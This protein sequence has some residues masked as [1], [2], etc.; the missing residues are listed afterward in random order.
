MCCTFFCYLDNAGH[1]FHGGGGVFPCATQSN[2][3]WQCSQLPWLSFVTTRL[4]FKV[5]NT[6]FCV[7]L[8]LHCAKSYMP[9]EL[10]V[11]ENDKLQNEAKMK[12]MFQRGSARGPPRGP[13]SAEMNNA[14]AW[15]IGMP[16]VKFVM[17]L[18]AMIA[19]VRTKRVP[20]V[21]D[22][23]KDIAVTLTWTSVSDDGSLLFW[24]MFFT[25]CEW[26]G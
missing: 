16:V 20:I 12:A 9:F 22:G 1:D 8:G 19:C 14:S 11:N 17:T 13:L 21:R 10:F 4:S 24:T 5:S 25:V 18:F 2:L 7:A 15:K 3:L 6:V 26:Q 23:P